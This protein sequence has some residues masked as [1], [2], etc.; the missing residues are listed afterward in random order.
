MMIKC[1]LV[2]VCIGSAC[3]GTVAS[4]AAHENIREDSRCK[5]VFTKFRPLLS[6]DLSQ[7]TQEY[8]KTNFRGANPGWVCSTFDL[9]R[10]LDNIHCFVLMVPR[11]D[12]DIGATCLIHIS[13]IGTEK[14]TSEIVEDLSAYSEPRNYIFLVYI[15][16]Q[17]I[18]DRSEDESIEMSSDGIEVINFEKSSYALFWHN[19]KL[20][21]VWT[22]D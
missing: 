5:S 22:S 6:E 7:I 9:K 20:L 4:P 2:Y 19:D 12:S 1:I 11:D 15:K 3:I 18:I 17:K 8:F 14:A 10:S 16:R 13:G 21:K